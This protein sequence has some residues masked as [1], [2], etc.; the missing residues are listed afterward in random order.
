MALLNSKGESI[1]YED[2]I[3][4]KTNA[5]VAICG[6]GGKTTTMYNLVRHFCKNNK[7]I[8]ST[9]THIIK[10]DKY[11]D[12]TE[13]IT[14]YENNLN[15]WPFLFVGKMA[16]SIRIQ[17]PN[18]ECLNWAIDN[19][20]LFVYEAD[21]AKERPIKIPRDT[22]PVILDKTNYALIVVG[23]SCLHRSVYEIA[24]RQEE[25]A[26]LLSINEDDIID[27]NIIAR[28]IIEG[29]LT[30]DKLKDINKI[31][32]LNQ[33]DNKELINAGINIY[34]IIDKVTNVDYY[35][36]IS[37]YDKGERI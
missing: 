18:E 30:N 27:E 4:L 13:D 17:A 3:S 15:I 12:L 26:N 31:V 32:I 29:Y 37:S 5:L 6:A 25:F 14:S 20:N 33:A 1:K 19:S 9:T 34:D 23:L 22:E 35:G 11:C 24:G 10:P 36:V 16:D 8:A 21:G 7:V 2:I 28:S